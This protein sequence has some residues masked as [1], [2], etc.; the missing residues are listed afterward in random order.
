MAAGVCCLGGAAGRIKE[1][2][3]QMR[4]IG[5]TDEQADRGRMAGGRTGGRM[6]VSG[7]QDGVTGLIEELGE[8]L[9]KLGSLGDSGGLACLV[10][11]VMPCQGQV[12]HFVRYRV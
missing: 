12:R 1:T 2:D 4:R 6:E 9:G 11:A 5:E 10:G 3:Q 7:R 8:E